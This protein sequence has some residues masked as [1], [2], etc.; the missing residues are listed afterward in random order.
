MAYEFENQTLSTTRA[1]INKGQGQSYSEHSINCINGN[2]TS[3]DSIMGG[4]TELYSI[5]GWQPY[6][7]IRTVKQNVNNV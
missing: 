2:Q 4:L 6:D 3:A 7:V 5:V 1:K